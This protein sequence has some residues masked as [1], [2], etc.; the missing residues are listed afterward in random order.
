MLHAALFQ[1]STCVFIRK[2]TEVNKLTFCLTSDGY[3]LICQFLANEWNST[4]SVTVDM[5][6]FYVDKYVQFS[7][8]NECVL[9]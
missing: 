4:T 2:F 5:L 3:H 9:L 1:P 6:S 7:V 8:F